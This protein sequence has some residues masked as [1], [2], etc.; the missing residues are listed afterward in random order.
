MALALL[1][2]SCWQ[3]YLSNWH[4]G[5]S[6]ILVP[7]HDTLFTIWNQRDQNH[8]FLFSSKV[9]GNSLK[10]L[11]YFEHLLKIKLHDCMYCMWLNM[12]KWWSKNTKYCETRFRATV[13]VRKLR[14]PL[15]PWRF[16]LN[17]VWKGTFFSCSSQFDTIIVSDSVDPQ[18]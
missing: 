11:K 8:N 2:S 6:N 1:V 7:K 14:W 5:V 9:V 13:K 18:K 16:L 3:L 15:S 10:H 12:R 17:L 4:D